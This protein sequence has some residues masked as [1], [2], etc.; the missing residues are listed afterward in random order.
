MPVSLSTSSGTSVLI[1]GVECGYVN[2]PL[3]N[4]SFSSDFA[5]GIVAV[6][7]K[8]SLPFKGVHLMLGND[9]TGDKVMVDPLTNPVLIN[10]L[11]L[12]SRKI[13]DLYPSCAVTNAMTKNAN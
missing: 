10:Q 1:E 9:L 3:H 8:H 5:T 6:G 4:I 2:V 13:H 11:I 12:M 7:I